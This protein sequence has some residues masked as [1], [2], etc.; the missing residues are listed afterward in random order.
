MFEVPLSVAA[1]VAVL[2]C[3]V[4]RRPSRSPAAPRISAPEHT[5]VVRRVVGWTFRSHS[6]TAWSAITVAVIPISGSP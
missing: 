2:Q 1:E 3:V 4:A 6:R 5:D